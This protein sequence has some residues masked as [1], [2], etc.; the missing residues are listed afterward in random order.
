MIP[1]KARITQTVFEALL[2]I[3]GYFFWG[4]DTSFVL[5]WFGLDWISGIVLTYLKTRKR[6]NYS[7][8]EHEQKLAKQRLLLVSGAFVIT[9]IATWFTLPQLNHIFSWKE[10]IWAFLSYADMGI[11]Q[12]IIIVPLIALN[13]YLLYNNIFLKFRLYEHIGMRQLTKHLPYEAILSASI[14][15]LA[16]I[17][18]FVIE[19]PNEILL[20]GSIIG[21]TVFRLNSRD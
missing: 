21:I 4:W 8:Q 17:M 11:P 13:G 10:R 14:S 6:Y 19:Y 5:M 20:F 9:S 1:Q 18:S 12:G 2:P 15:V 16:L 3:L 7:R